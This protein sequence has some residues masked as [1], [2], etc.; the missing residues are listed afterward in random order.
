MMATDFEKLGVFYLGKKYDLAN[1]KIEEEYILYDA[2][3]LV[4]HAVCVGMTGSGKTGLCLAL[5]EEAALDGIPAILID[6]KGDL[7][8]LLLTFPDLLPENFKPWVNVD[9]ASNKGM[10]V[11]DYAAQQAQ[12][13]EKGIRSWGQ[14]GQRIRQ[15]R[16][17]VEFR[18]YTPGSN[19]GIPVSI[20]HSFNAPPEAQREDNEFMRDRVITTVTS[21]LQLIG[22]DADPN[23]SREAILMANLLDHNWRKGYDLSLEMLISQIQNPPIQ[24][25]GVMDLDMYYPAKERF[26]L[27]MSLN[28]LLAS[29]GF[30]I[31]L[32]GDPLDVDEIIRNQQ[33]KP[34]VAIFSIAHLNDAERMFFV[35]LLLNQ[36]L[37][38]MRSQSGTNSL[39]TILYMDEIFGFLPPTRNP[40]SK[41]PML[42]LLKQARA[43]GLGLVLA[44]QN[45]VD[46]DYKALSNTGTWF[47]GRLQT[48]RDKARLIEGLEGAAAAQSQKFD[49]QRMEQIIAGLG[50][51]VFL[52][53]NVHDDA[54]VVFTTRWVMSYMRGPLTRDQIKLLMDPVKKNVEKESTAAPSMEA[55]EPKKPTAAKTGSVPTLPPDIQAVYLP[56]RHAGKETMYYP[57]VLAAARTRFVDAKLNI[58][59]METGLFATF[60]TENAIAVD[61]QKGKLLKI[62]PDLLEKTGKGGAAYA[63]LPDAGRQKSNY[64]SWAKDFLNWVVAAQPLTLLRSPSR[65]VIS[66]PGEGEKDFRIRV[67]QMKRENR[68]ERLVKIREKYSAKIS[69]LREKIEKAETRVAK[70]RGQATSAA[71]SLGASVLGALTGR[72]LSTSRLSTAIRGVGRST[73]QS[74]DV[75]QAKATLNDYKQQLKDLE[76]EFEEEKK[77]MGEGVDPLTEKLETVQVKMKKTDIT[78]QLFSLAWLPFTRDEAGKLSAAW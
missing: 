78:V 15:L 56:V 72:K 74:G 45:P 30:N 25:I 5:I 20:L 76:A 68:D 26:A 6:P 36:V 46:L 11:D 31:W 75:R 54:P 9:D 21:L 61:W 23:Q 53:N 77:T 57:A 13:W 18:I 43:F 67:A 33:G 37:G 69:T 1:K 17:K 39:R 70:E 63:E 64:S 59:Q 3:D 22:I 8:N 29:P 47:I 71:I 48:E 44:T 51:R 40:A 66:E 27:V 34:R 49:K 4:T 12:T 14:D 32:Q 50:N 24:K 52:M 65:G 7:A 62:S 16:E 42:T 41:L 38:W 73:E 60:I 55:D 28:N 35:S 10:T 2:K 19:A 58:D